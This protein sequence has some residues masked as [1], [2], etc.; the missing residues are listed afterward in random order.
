MKL[1]VLIKAERSQAAL[2]L[3]KNNQEAKHP[4]QDVTKRKTRGERQHGRRRLP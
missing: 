2:H 4:G 3:K 1:L